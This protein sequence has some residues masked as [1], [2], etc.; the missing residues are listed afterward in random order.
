M[1]WL[2]LKYHRQSQSQKW[3]QIEY[4]KTFMYWLHEKVSKELSDQNNIS[5]NLKWIAQAPRLD[6]IKFPG[7]IINGFRY[8]TKDW[9][10]SR[11][12]QNNGV[13]LVATTMQVTGYKD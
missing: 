5:N 2:K 13:S 3:L 10:N 8:H 11:V 7:Y 6:A 1:A 4:N 12:S 9:D